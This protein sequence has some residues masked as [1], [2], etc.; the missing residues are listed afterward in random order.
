MRDT[1]VGFESRPTDETLL[2]AAR[3]GDRGA[4]TTLFTRHHTG[5]VRYARSLVQSS[6]EAE[7]L[8]AESFLRMMN[9]LRAGKGPVGNVPAYLRTTVRRLTIDVGA[10]T[11][12]SVPSGLDMGA[13]ECSSIWPE[14]SMSLSESAVERAFLSLS[15]RWRRVLWM[16]DV[17]GYRPGEL[18]T[19]LG[20][21]PA[22]ACSLLW[23][24]RR[25]LKEQFFELVHGAG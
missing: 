12:R 16:V 3:T 2:E 22:A 8:A 7:D 20:I 19:A 10:K 5:T 11:G 4:L 18:A 14:P 17:L 23:R 13:L 6:T 24:A 15:P 9:A 25:A 1:L 21:A